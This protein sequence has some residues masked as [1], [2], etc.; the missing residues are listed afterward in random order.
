MPDDEAIL[1]RA[2]RAAVQLLTELTALGFE[3]TCEQDRVVVRSSTRP[4]DERLRARI[5]AEKA[6]LLTLVSYLE[7]EQPDPDSPI[8]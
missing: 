3:V 2:P 4:L 5:R 1:L 8:H 7:S 6:G